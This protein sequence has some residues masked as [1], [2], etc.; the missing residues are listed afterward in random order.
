MLL[1]ATTIIILWMSGPP[2]RIYMQTPLCRC[3]APIPAH[4][5]GCQLGCYLADCRTSNPPLIEDPRLQT[6]KQFT[7]QDNSAEHVTTS[8]TSLLTLQPAPQKPTADLQSLINKTLL[9]TLVQCRRAAVTE[10]SVCSTTHS[11]STQ[12]QDWVYDAAHLQSLKHLFMPA[13]CGCMQCS[14]S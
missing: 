5:L 8:T 1:S 10:R 14:D 4:K 12:H 11:P 9:P 7:L 6:L 3:R 13:M 2:L